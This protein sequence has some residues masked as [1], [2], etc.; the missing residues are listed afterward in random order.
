MDMTMWL[1]AKFQEASRHCIKDRGKQMESI[2]QGNSIFSKWWL[3]RETPH[4]YKGT[5]NIWEKMTWHSQQKQSSQHLSAN[6][7]AAV[8]LKQN[9]Q[10]CLTYCCRGLWAVLLW[11]GR[12]EEN[13]TS[14]GLTSSFTLFHLW[15]WR[16]AGDWHLQDRHSACCRVQNCVV[17]TSSFLDEDTTCQ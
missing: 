12:E 1:I 8:L 15:K 14:A 9:S 6:R 5:Q 13:I 11:N 10:G 3:C 4:Q 7:G 2:Q 17:P 16:C